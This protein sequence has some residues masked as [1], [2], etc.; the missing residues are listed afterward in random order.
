MLVHVAK[1]DQAREKA[2]RQEL[3][4]FYLYIRVL[5]W[6]KAWQEIPA[7][8]SFCTVAILFALITKKIMQASA[9]Q[10]LLDPEVSSGVFVFLALLKENGFKEGYECG[11][12]LNATN[13]VPD[14]EIF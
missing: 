1:C 8:L 12:W 2:K 9:S 14:F 6:L 7:G 11:G 3:D 10:G 13:G 4:D 5:L